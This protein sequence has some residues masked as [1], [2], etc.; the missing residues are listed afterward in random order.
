TMASFRQN[1]LR[2]LYPII[3]KNGK[4]GKNGTVLHNTENVIAPQSF[5]TI[6]T[7]LNN[8]KTLDFAGFS[9]KKILIV[10]TASDCGYTG[11][12]AELQKLYEQLGDKLLII[13]FPANDFAKQEQGGDTDIAQICTMNYRVTFQIAI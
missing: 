3:K 12:Y 2:F 8:G 13:A 7:V 6:R 11:Q 1:I 4:L 10:N 5:H 9:G